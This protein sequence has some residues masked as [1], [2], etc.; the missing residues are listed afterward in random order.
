MCPLAHRSRKDVS[1]QV[2]GMENVNYDGALIN[3]LPL[4]Y[5]F[6]FQYLVHGHELDALSIS[7][8]SKYDTMLCQ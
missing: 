3:S 7:L 1:T 5:K 2:L 4:S 8:C 6:T